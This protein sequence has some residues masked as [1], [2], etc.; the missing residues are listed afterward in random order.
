MVHRLQRISTSPENAVKFLQAFYEIDVSE[1]ARQV[2][3]PALV[4]HARTDAR[5]PFAAGR[6]L[7][8]LIPS[9]RFVSRWITG[10]GRCS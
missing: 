9:A 10:V 2:V 3:T 8:A 7:A 5:I 6:E 4:V 1:L